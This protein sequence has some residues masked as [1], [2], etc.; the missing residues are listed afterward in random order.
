MHIHELINVFFFSTDPCISLDHTRLKALHKAMVTGWSQ[1][2]R[3]APDSYKADGFLEGHKPISM[4]SKH[5]QNQP[6]ASRN[7]L[8]DDMASWNRGVDYS[9]I[10]VENIAL[11]THLKC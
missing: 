11:A 4:A 5:G 8:E 2:V 7:T 10:A 1:W 9:K 3:D 6:I